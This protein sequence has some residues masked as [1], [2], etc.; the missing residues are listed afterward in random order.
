M[1]GPE[2]EKIERHIKRLVEH[3]IGESQDL[4]EDVVCDKIEIHAR[5]T[6]HNLFSEM[7]WDD[8]YSDEEDGCP[9]MSD[10]Y[11]NEVVDAIEKAIADNN[12]KINSM[13]NAAKE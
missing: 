13:I 11:E 8:L 3:I 7:V 1:I 12:E 10:E 4:I 9:P 6:L 2:R 5:N